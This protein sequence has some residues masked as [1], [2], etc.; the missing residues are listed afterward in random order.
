MTG[1]SQLLQNPERVLRRLKQ[2]APE[3][4][5][6]QRWADKVGQSDETSRTVEDVEALQNRVAQ[7]LDRG[8]ELRA[9]D[10]RE[11]CKAY[12]HP[13]CPPGRDLEL[14]AKL[15]D[16]VVE[17]QRRAPM[18]A[19]ID[20]YL[21][22]FDTED[23][24]LRR[25]AV[26]LDA[27]C[28]G[29]PWKEGTSWPS[30]AKT[31]DLFDPDKAPSRIAEAVLSADESP[32]QVLD[33]A[34]LHTDIR[35]KGGLAEEAFR[36]GCNIAAAMAGPPAQP[37]QERLVDWAR[38]AGTPLAYP[39]AWPNYARS[40]FVPFRRMEPQ[41]GHR[42]ALI[43]AATAYA[44]DPRINQARWR[45]IMEEHQDA[46]EVI[47]R[48]LTKASVEQ[49]FDIVSQTMRDRPDMWKERRQFWTDYLR[50]NLISAAWVAFGSDGAWRADD[51][52]KRSNDPALKMF[53]RLASGSGKSPE[54]AAL[55][56]QIGDLIV[57]DWSHNGSWN[58]WPITA[59]GRP[60]LFRQNS[61]GWSDY[62]ARELMHAPINGPHT[63][64]GSWRSRVREIISDHTGLRP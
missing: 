2:D 49:F 26:K 40:L 41:E 63:A 64:N 34:G 46:Y 38:M 43:E 37:V 14:A 31:F 20:T 18:L 6:T 48:W 62:D 16:R 61:R 47:L 57:V 21:D 59:K 56:M 3:P 23:A 25:L 52:A 11:V 24:D 29:W 8:L 45:P 28:P 53:G 10:V 4:R 19:L 5:D 60:A 35:R 17:I 32:R 12:F 50:A 7:A 42:R 44:G 51:L 33:S 55:I 39:R 9:R 54:H 30:R 36:R 27:L 22:R 15:L 1:L 13:P 58:I